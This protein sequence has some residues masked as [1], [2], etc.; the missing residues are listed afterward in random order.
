M[1][2]REVRL[3]ELRR[4]QEKGIDPYPGITF[5]PTHTTVEIL[6]GYPENPGA[7]SQVRLAG[8]LW[9]KRLMGKASFAVLA[10]EKGLIQLYF[11]QADFEDPALY[12]EVFKK[13]LDLGDFIGIE[14]FVFQ[15]KTGEITVHVKN[16]QLLAKCLSPFPVPKEVDGKT[17]E[18]LTDPD[19]RYRYRYLDLWVHPRVREVFLLR[20]K[21]V[22][23]MRDFFLSS[24][25]HEVETPILQPVYG[26]A[27]AR[28]FV[29]HLHALDMPMYLRIANELYLKRLIVGGFEG[30]FEF[31]KDFRN[32]GVDRFHNPEFTQV[33]LYVAYKDYLWMMD[34]VEAL[35]RNVVQKAFGKLRISSWGGVEI[36][37]E[38]PFARRKYFDLLQEKLGQDPRGLSLEALESLARQVGITETYDQ[39]IDYVEKLFDRL[40]EPSLVEPTFVYDYPI[41]LSPLARQRPG[42]P[43]AERFELICNGKEIA[44]AYSELNDPIEQRK[45]LE[46]Q[47]LLRDKNPEAMQVDEDFLTALMYGMPPTAGLGIGIDRLTMLLT[48]APAIQEVIFFPLLRP[49]GVEVLDS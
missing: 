7:F 40:V 45:R 22:Q 20:G 19:L 26:G 39:K 1:Q 23:A 6:T 5:F 4:L 16:F 17:Y 38:K 46:A 42:E 41:E 28:P 30:V 43:L 15:T 31:A 14:G 2:E 32:E 3:Q 12:D 44:N 8:R 21:I 9:T 35:L 24:G 25:Y 47:A 13:L 11:R 18:V 33:E 27:F 36:D 49:L 48:G 29:T 10:D 37:F 34:Y